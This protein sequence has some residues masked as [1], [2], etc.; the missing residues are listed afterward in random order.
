MAQQMGGSG[1]YYCQTE[2]INYRKVIGHI[3]ARVD[4]T[5]L[6][7]LG[8]HSQRQKHLRTDTQLSGGNTKCRFENTKFGAG[9]TKFDTGNTTFG[10]GNARF[11]S[12]CLK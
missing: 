3:L 7:G 5:T 2:I 4:G 1:I 11:G 10:P 6:S 12:G 9:K 8:G